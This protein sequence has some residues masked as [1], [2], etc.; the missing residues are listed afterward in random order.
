MEDAEVTENREDLAQVVEAAM[1]ESLGGSVGEG[2]HLFIGEDGVE[3]L[4][5]EEEV[6]AAKLELLVGRE[7]VDPVA[8]PE[9]GGVAEE[10]AGVLE[11]ELGR[12]DRPR[13]D[14]HSAIGGQDFCHG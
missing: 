1:L 7:A 3:E 14:L 10:L 6:E 2:T 11:H 5:G 13:V 8:D 12:S 9:G 4:H